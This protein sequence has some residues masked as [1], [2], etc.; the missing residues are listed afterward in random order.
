MTQDNIRHYLLSHRRH[1]FP[2]YFASLCLANEQTNSFVLPEDQHEG[3][4]YTTR[5]DSCT[6]HVP[7]H[8]FDDL[9]LGTIYPS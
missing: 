3:I 1:V 7:V 8:V 9:S 2:S 4:A 5:L 6:R